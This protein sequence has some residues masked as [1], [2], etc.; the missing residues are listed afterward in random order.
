MKTLMHILMGLMFLIVA[1]A[2][3]VAGKSEAEVPEQTTIETAVETGLIV[4]FWTAIITVTGTVIIIPVVRMILN[5]L[6]QRRKSQES[7]DHDHDHD[8][9]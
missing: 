5:H 8:T 9:E 3:A 7:C 2:S 4:E 6:K 1:A